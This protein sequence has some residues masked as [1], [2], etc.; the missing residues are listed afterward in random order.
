M[1]FR[2]FSGVPGLYQL[3][4]SSTL[5]PGLTNKIGSR[6]CQMFPGGQNDTLLRIIVV[7][8]TVDK[9][10]QFPDLHQVRKTNSKY[11]RM[12]KLDYY[13]LFCMI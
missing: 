2:I 6:L 8:K 10:N 3:D 13:G 4:A 1:H 9:T 5:F 11:I 12:N 7:N